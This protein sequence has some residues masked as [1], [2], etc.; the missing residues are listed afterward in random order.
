MKIIILIT[1][2]LILSVAISC[3][4]KDNPVTEKKENELTKEDFRFTCNKMLE[5][6]FGA[7][8]NLNLCMTKYYSYYHSE[9][10]GINAY[11]VP[12]G[13]D[14]K[15]YKQCIEEKS[16]CTEYSSC[17]DSLM[18]KHENIETSCDKN[19]F[20][21]HC[22]DKGSLLFCYNSVVQEYYCPFYDK[23]CKKEPNAN[24]YFKEN[25]PSCENANGTSCENENMVLCR[26]GKKLITSCTEHYGENFTCM[27]FSYPSG[28]FNKNTYGCFYE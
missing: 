9:K 18:A 22:N 27:S 13:E 14:I 17:F 16:N 21:N 10:G 26:D 11:Y 4:E 1:T 19:T 8:E 25:T 3:G 23:I 24:C 7:E 28:G 5:C 12:V 6:N 2:F 20:V 15:I